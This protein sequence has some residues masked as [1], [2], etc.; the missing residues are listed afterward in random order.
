MNSS[1]T[2]GAL[3]DQV[4]SNET[5]PSTSAKDNGVPNVPYA[6]RQA[7]SRGLLSPEYGAA[8]LTL[9]E[10]EPHLL[11]R[12]LSHRSHSRMNV[13]LDSPVV[14]RNNFG[15]G[16]ATPVGPRSSVTVT[17]RPRATSDTAHPGADKDLMTTSPSTDT[18][19]NAIALALEY[20]D[21][22]RQAKLLSTTAAEV[23]KRDFEAAEAEEEMRCRLDNV[24]KEGLEISRRL[25]Y[26][27]YTLLEK[28][29]SLSSIVSQFQS[30]RDQILGF[31]SK[32]GSD[33]E[34]LNEDV[35]TNIN[36]I[37]GKAEGRRMERVEQLETRMKL[38]REK[39]TLLGNRLEAARHI[40]T[41]YEDREIEYRAKIGRRFKMT[42]ISSLI[43]ICI[44]VL[45]G[46]RGPSQSPSGAVSN[47]SSSSSVVSEEINMDLFDHNRSSQFLNLPAHHQN[48][49]E[50][51][52]SV[53]IPDDVVNILLGSNTDSSSPPA[54]HTHDATTSRPKAKTDRSSREPT[55]ESYLHQQQKIDTKPNYRS[56]LGEAGIEFE[57]KDENLKKI[58]DEL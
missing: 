13:S 23:A 4:P 16:T 49:A 30:L 41:E 32:V 25:D 7:G 18:E 57:D 43:L 58:F 9:N 27:Y 38:G 2:D 34:T 48:L 21:K 14:S 10:R 6:L 22:K 45:L 15:S 51:L 55:S 33:L 11:R 35:T 52:K 54:T 39:A 47:S 37:R 8:S 1:P 50:R 28:R 5:Q 53:Y 42:W 29:T 17:G 56:R 46:S 24:T 20:G 40:L 3:N 12:A 36:G 19:A 31:R 26:T 44:V